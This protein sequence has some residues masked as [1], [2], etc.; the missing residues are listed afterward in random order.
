MI[1]EILLTKYACPSRNAA[2]DI[3]HF[4]VVHMNWKTI[5]D[6]Q[7]VNFPFLIATSIVVIL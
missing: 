3:V 6:L 4:F 5:C 7:Y 1:L 2:E